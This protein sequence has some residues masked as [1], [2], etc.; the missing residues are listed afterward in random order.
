MQATTTYFSTSPKF[1]QAHAR[2]GL[3]PEGLKE[4]WGVLHRQY[5]PLQLNKHL[6][7]CNSRAIPESLGKEKQKQKIFEKGQKKK[8]KEKKRSRSS[9][10]AGTGAQARLFKATM[11]EIKW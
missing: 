3:H 6:L 11:V 7:L 10:K 2:R 1:F 9:A 8:K 4:A 5:H